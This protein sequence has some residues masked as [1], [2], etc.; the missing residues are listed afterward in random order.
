MSEKTAYLVLEDVGGWPGRANLYRVSEPMSAFD[1]KHETDYVIV[2]VVPPAKHTYA[3]CKIVPAHESG[4]CLESSV[5]HRGGSF[6]P[7][8]NPFEDVAHLQG[9]YTWALAMAGYQLVDPPEV[10]P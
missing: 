6:T 1:G 3:Q 10:A 2:Y 5:R 4:G 9:C 8:G 7:H